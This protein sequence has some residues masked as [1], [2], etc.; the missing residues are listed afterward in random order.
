MEKFRSSAS[1]SNPFA[2]TAEAEQAEETP[3]IL[4]LFGNQ[5]MQRWPFLFFLKYNNKK[6]ILGF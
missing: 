1:A 3:N 5:L 2:V 4:D 6:L